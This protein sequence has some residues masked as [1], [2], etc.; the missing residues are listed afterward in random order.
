MSKP[1]P[2]FSMEQLIE[3]LRSK[4]PAVDENGARTSDNCYCPLE[5]VTGNV[6]TSSVTG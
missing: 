1:T 3:E 2:S 6:T 4:V 5:R